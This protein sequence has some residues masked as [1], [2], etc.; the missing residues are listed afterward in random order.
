MIIPSNDYLI[1]LSKVCSLNNVRLILD[2]IQTG[3]FRTGPLFNSSQYELNVSFMTM[4]KGIAG[5]FPFAAFAMT[6][7]VSAELSI[8][9]HGGTYCGNPLGCAVS[10]AV[11][12]YMFEN[13]IS[14]NVGKISR[15]VFE[16]LE[17]L[18][19]D[20]PEKIKE[21]RGKGLLIAM[22]LFDGKLAL[23]IQKE[24]LKNGLLINVTQGKILRFFR[25]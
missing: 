16:T 5:G 25:L 10:L 1:N 22:E 15:L 8:G 24:S 18:E 4:A 14:E 11:I 23:D 21:I 12:K 20:F 6:E 3:F 13:N 19:K 17:V 9:D 7:E 2:E